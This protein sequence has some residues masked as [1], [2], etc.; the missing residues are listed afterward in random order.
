MTRIEYKPRR[1]LLSKGEDKM[2]DNEHRSNGVAKTAMVGRTVYKALAS[3]VL[4]R[5]REHLHYNLS[6][7]HNPNRPLP[8]L[9]LSDRSCRAKNFPRQK[10]HHPL[11]LPITAQ[12]P[13]TIQRQLSA[14]GKG[15]LGLQAGMT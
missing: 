13:H 1:A 9:Q 14:L 15:K 3:S 8:L 11:F 6:Q 7:R 12:P 4:S 5:S 10:S 2:R